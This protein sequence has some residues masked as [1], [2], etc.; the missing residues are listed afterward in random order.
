MNRE[1]EPLYRKVNSKARGCHHRKGT[2][3]KY[4]RHTKEGMSTKM[5]RG[6]HRG[7]DYTPLYK[8]LLSKV[9]KNWDDVYSEAVSR[10]VGGDPAMIY[11]LIVRP[12]DNYQ[13][14]FVRTGESTYYNAL[15]VGDDN[16]LQKV[17]PNFTQNDIIPLCA[18]CTHTFNGKPITRKYEYGKSTYQ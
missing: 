16:I 2:D 14:S 18:C 11:V 1:K 8:F 3:A 7:L 13:A 12:N 15:Y 6:E 10:L 5:K 17:D 9:G 4:D